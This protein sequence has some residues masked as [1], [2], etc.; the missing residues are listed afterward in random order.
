MLSIES[1]IEDLKKKQNAAIL[2]HNYQMPDVQD[3]ADFVGD[4]LG[5]SIEAKKTNADLIIFCG[6]NFMAETAKI[7]N[8]SKKVVM[9][10]A[11]AGCPMANMIN[12][13]D[14]I[15]LRK[16]NP[17]AKVVCYVNTT[18]EVKAES[19]ICCTSGNAVNVV[20]SI[21]DDEIIFVPDQYLGSHV[22][23]QTGKKMILWP[24]F[25]RTHVKILPEH[26]IAAK[27]LHPKALVLCH[28]ECTPQ[29]RKLSDF[30]ASTSKMTAFPESTDAKEFIIATE[31]GIIHQLE[32]IYPD[33]KFYPAYND[34]LC[35]N[36][37]L[38]T[39]EK[40]LWCLEDG[41]DEIT[42]PQKTQ[43]KALV[44]IERMLKVAA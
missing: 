19:D 43:E 20:K 13:R 27:K 18:A 32:K 31:I 40:V 30:V 8:P 35:P 10:D 3:V 34:I 1:K 5:L 9:P 4:S 36:M 21:I 11:R 44:A 37:K 2:A 26:I 12:A 29:I 16:Q 6:V 7:L 23:D 14:V 22:E 15:N 25:C 41:G 17:K 39:L 24:G 42:I 38:T 28:P 33:K